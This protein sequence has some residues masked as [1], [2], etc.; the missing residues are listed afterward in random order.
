MISHPGINVIQL[1][2]QQKYSLVYDHD[3]IGLK[4]ALSCENT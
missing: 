4:S 1:S 2:I 3:T